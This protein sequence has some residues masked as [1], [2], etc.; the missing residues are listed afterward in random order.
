MSAGDVD[1]KATKKLYLD[2]SNNQTYLVES[3]NDVLD[4][5]VGGTNLL[6]LEESG[7]CPSA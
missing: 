1:I 3:S 5:Y 2:G 6:R 4:I 7:L